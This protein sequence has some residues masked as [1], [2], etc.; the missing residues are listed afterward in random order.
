MHVDG[1]LGAYARRRAHRDVRGERLDRLETL[2]PLS[3]VT[4]VRLNEYNGTDCRSIEGMASIGTVMKLWINQPSCCL[5]DDNGGGVHDSLHVLTHANARGAPRP[6]S[7]AC[8][9]GLRSAAF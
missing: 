2:R 7:T 3:R 4:Y 1:L 5:M 6:A 8:T 9:Y